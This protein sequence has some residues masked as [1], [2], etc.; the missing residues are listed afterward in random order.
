MTSI[1][2]F[3]IARNKT[4]R[5]LQKLENQK[6]AQSQVSNGR[7]CACAGNRRS[8]RITPSHRKARWIV[9]WNK[10]NTSE[11]LIDRLNQNYN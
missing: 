11:E 7:P 6:T 8:L 2:L 10:N 9:K 5:N 4:D 3:R 1:W